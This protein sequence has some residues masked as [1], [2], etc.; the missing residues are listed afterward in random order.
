MD[1]TDSQQP[2]QNNNFCLRETVLTATR[3]LQVPAGTT[4]LSINSCTSD[5]WSKVTAAL[6]GLTNLT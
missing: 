1:R 5:D 3:I 2:P 6:S 4:M